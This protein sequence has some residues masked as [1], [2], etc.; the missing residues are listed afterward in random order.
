MEINWQNLSNVL[1]VVQKLKWSALV[2]N[3][4]IVLTGTNTI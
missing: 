4:T 2:I 3:A 1:F